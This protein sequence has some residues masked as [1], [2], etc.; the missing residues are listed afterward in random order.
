MHINAYTV[1]IVMRRIGVVVVVVGIAVISAEDTRSTIVDFPTRPMEKF[2]GAHLS[3]G[4][5]PAIFSRDRACA[6][7]ETRG[8]NARTRTH[9]QIKPPW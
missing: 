6:E 8:D 1:S 3:R 5:T 9:T 2:G 4:L 7:S